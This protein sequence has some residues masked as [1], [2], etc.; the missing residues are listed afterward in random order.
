MSLVMPAW[1]ECDYVHLPST[2]LK[3][4]PYGDIAIVIAKHMTE[5]GV[6]TYSLFTLFWF[7]FPSFN[8]FIWKV[9]VHVFVT[10]SI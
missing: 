6:H 2:F 9:C 3:V 5:I 8:S 1:V 4:W 7:F 10:D